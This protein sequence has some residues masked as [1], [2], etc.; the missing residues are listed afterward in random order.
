MDRRST[1]AR[2]QCWHRAGVIEM[3]VGDN[4]GIGIDVANGI[5]HRGR[6]LDAV[7][8]KEAVIDNDGTP[9]DLAGSAEELH[10]HY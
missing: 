4:N 1:I 5:L 6:R 9:A 8:E 2:Q 10:I 3:A 7:V